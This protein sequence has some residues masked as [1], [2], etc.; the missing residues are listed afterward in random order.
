[1]TFLILYRF[2]RN[3]KSKSW[4][5]QKMCSKVS[6]IYKGREECGKLPESLGGHFMKL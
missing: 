1:M 4:R 3:M 6:E 5:V 2:S